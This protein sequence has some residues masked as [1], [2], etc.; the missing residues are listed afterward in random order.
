MG[1]QNKKSS[2]F[3]WIRIIRLYLLCMGLLFF[4]WSAL[5][6]HSFAAETYTPTFRLADHFMATGKFQAAV[7]TLRSLMQKQLTPA[8]E[9]KA[10]FLLGK[11]FLLDQQHEMASATFQYL[12]QTW[13]EHPYTVE[14]DFLEID[15]ELSAMTHLG[16]FA[17]S[18]EKILRFP[19]FN[20]DPD[21]FKY[22][23]GYTKGYFFA[24]YMGVK[25]RLMPYLKSK[26]AD[27]RARAQ[28][29]A[30]LIEGYDFQNK[31]AGLEYLHEVSGSS[32][33]FLAHIASLA[34][35]IQECSDNLENLEALK[36]QIPKNWDESEPGILSMTLFAMV[37]AYIHGK[38]EDALKMMEHIQ[39]IGPSGI[40]ST[41]TEHISVLKVISTSLENP[42]ALLDKAKVFE[43]YSSFHQA[44]NLYRKAVMTSNDKGI[45]ARS[46]YAIGRILQDD[47]KDPEGAVEAF[48][49]A[50]KFKLPE[51]LRQE[52]QWRKIKALPQKKQSEAM[53]KYAHGQFP[54]TE[55]AI[56]EQMQSKNP[57]SRFLDR[58]FQSL[59]DLGLEPLSQKQIL[60]SL[61]QLALDSHQFFKARFFLLK[62]AKFDL[63]TASRLLKETE[64]RE[65]IF[66]AENS[67]LRSMEPE[68]YRFL[69]GTYLMELNETARGQE[70][71]QNLS[72]SK[73]LYSHKAGF[74][75]FENAMGALPY[76]NEIMARL[77]DF[78]LSDPDP[79]IQRSALQRLRK[80]YQFLFQDQN[81]LDK[82]EREKLFKNEFP[83]YLTILKEG[84][85]R[86][87]ELAGTLRFE[88][89]YLLIQK[90]DL[91]EAKKEVDWLIQFSDPQKS[92]EI[93]YLWAE[94]DHDPHAP[95]LALELVQLVRKNKKEARAWLL[96][97]Y[98]MKKKQILESEGLEHSDELMG[99][100][101]LMS[102]FLN[103]EPDLFRAE[104]AKEFLVIGQMA[105]QN[106]AILKLF[107]D[108]S[109]LLTHELGT[110][111]L[112]YVDAILEKEP[113]LSS[114]LISKLTILESHSGSSRQ[115]SFVLEQLH[116]DDPRVRASA[117]CNLA[118]S[119]S[120]NLLL[121]QFAGN[122]LLMNSLEELLNDSSFLNREDTL[123]LMELR[124]ILSDDSTKLR[125]QDDWFNLPPLEAEFISSKLMEKYISGGKIPSGL[126]LLSH[127]ME[128]HS[129]A[130][131]QY[132]L[133]LSL[134]RELEKS[135]KTVE[136]KPFLFKIKSNELKPENALVFNKLARDINSRSV[137]A[138]LSHNID[139]DDPQ[140]AKN[141]PHF[142]QMVDI[143]W[144]ETRDIPLVS[145]LL[146]QIRQ[147]FS[148]SEVQAKV[149]ELTNKIPLLHQ[150][151]RLE[152]SGTVADLESSGTIWLEELEDPDK[153]IELYQRAI[154]VQAKNL[155]KTYLKL[156]LARAY[157]YKKMF[158]E[159]QEIL[160]SM[161]EGQTSLTLP[162]IQRIEGSKA[163]QKLPAILRSD[164]NQLLERA[165]ILL[166]QLLDFP[167][168]EIVMK[169]IMLNWQK[170]GHS[171]TF[172]EKIGVLLLQ[173]YHSAMSQNQESI[174]LKHLK[175]AMSK[176]FPGSLRAQAYY[177]GGT[178]YASYQPNPQLSQTYFLK[179]SQQKH[180]D[181]FLLLNLMGL[182]R[183]Y[184]ETKQPAK[185]L[186][187]LGQIKQLMKN[188][189][190]N[191]ALQNIEEQEL[192]ISK[193]LVYSKIDSYLSEMDKPEPMIIL[194]S[195][196]ALQRRPEYLEEAEKKYLVYLRLE[197]DPAQ[198]EIARVE[199]A[200]LY[201]QLKRL[202]ESV[203][204]YLKVANETQSQ[205]RRFLANLAAI[206]ITGMQMR[207]FQRALDLGTSLSKNLLE[208][209]QSAE[210]EKVLGEIRDLRSRQKKLR[211][212]N[213][214]FN[215]F[216]AIRSIK[217][218]LYKA[219]NY[220][221]AAKRLESL[222]QATED[223]PLQ[224]GAHYELG[225]LYD[226]KLGEFL[227]ALTHYNQ[228]LERFEHDE[229]SPEVLL[230][231]AEIH[232][233]ELKSPEK[234]LDSYRQYL[235]R[236]PFAR[237]RLAVLFQVGELLIDYKR[238]Y[239]SA[240]DTYSDIS[241]A[242][243]QTEWDEKAK[244]A[245]ANLLSRQLSDFV[246]AIEVYEDLVE[247]NFQS[248]LAPEA[249]FKVGRIYEIQLNDKLRAI[250]AYQKV[251][252]RFPG[253][254]FATQ[255]RDQLEKIRRK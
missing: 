236:Y 134:F 219:R 101:K 122:S 226:L 54:Y 61:V 149:S 133:F 70:I 198:R 171:Q 135:G 215:H 152:D 36:N 77:R 153:A 106:P 56:L 195:A 165:S 16:S 74:Y 233:K 129:T 172:G 178:H 81:L 44:L 50:L 11:S 15:R 190:E 254:S 208:K 241:R 211:L 248:T 92:L 4:S 163:L 244:L 8:E 110:S 124:W 139:W 180:G 199:L 117:L 221:E 201:A 227:K 43:Q 99:T 187:I 164:M 39:R 212:S 28:L 222:A 78:F 224:T 125:H 144:K 156:Q 80:H 19:P 58:Y 181:E 87:P 32:N 213:L 3:T 140:N 85:D 239:S 107:K 192:A 127:S 230:R 10:T 191:P 33:L 45:K 82:P 242:Y 47:L 141:I 252:D 223:Y 160:D 225:R 228:F 255:A 2:A 173:A 102:Q 46:L 113:K 111:L 96:K 229:I 119:T 93:Q 161:P 231:V 200:E 76:E 207:N 145:N 65:K 214:S 37:N 183:V 60:G 112:S 128:N 177:L 193:G 253:S 162:L 186:E 38:F 24:D 189:D 185:A 169:Q 98:S 90:G 86:F 209:S 72:S 83:S 55:A 246:G 234:A 48:E 194:K 184:D 7:D 71:L 116:H 179:G 131:H 157:I 12:S 29:L 118:R 105:P 9:Q 204:Q 18:V 23:S 21:F 109:S 167:A 6:N 245:R 249:Q 158:S 237:K 89:A 42:S 103:N 120:P 68:K 104:F 132:S 143:A 79:E 148:D 217:E 108:H 240:L 57:D 14:I 202:G 64:L 247:R 170:A 235:D 238:D 5:L 41:L 146:T 114:A 138:A 35:L 73:G 51:E 22:F 67:M 232:L 13:P 142:L 159:A 216:P 91:K 250:D 53:Q 151:F 203:D 62:I 49:K 52:I 30:G 251:I 63:E 1:T 31:K 182:V 100:I 27:L 75:L 26:D 130:D 88:L 174:A 206:R 97:A 176:N 188:R 155:S 147:Y 154:A 220:A 126:A 115:I 59:L 121:K 137:L 136:L 175:T 123:T 205:S 168:F 84:L 66:Q 20:L 69:Q 210:L 196:R 94:A 17:Q 40:Q 166:N 243:P 197:S 25:P 95:Q 34:L 150:A 218:N